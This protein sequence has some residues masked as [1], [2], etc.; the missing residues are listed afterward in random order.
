MDGDSERIVADPGILVGKPV[1][2]GTRIPVCFV[3]EL[4][5]NGWSL[6][7]ILREYPQLSREDVVAALRYAAR[8]AGGGSSSGPPYSA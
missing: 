7:D 5:A 3:V 6:E 8:C 2:R 4:I 1:V